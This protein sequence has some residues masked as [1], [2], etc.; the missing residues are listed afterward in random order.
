M[1]N[2][3]RLFESAFGT[4]LERVIPLEENLVPIDG[5]TAGSLLWGSPA[6]APKQYLIQSDID[7]FMTS[8]EPGYFLVGFWGH[9]INSSAFYYSRVNAWSRVLFRLPYG[10]VYTDNDTMAQHIVQF[11]T[12]YFDFERELSK[13]VKD[14]IAIE[15]MHKAYYRIEMPDSKL[16]ESKKSLLASADFEMEFGLFLAGYEF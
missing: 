3:K 5:S 14:F 15:S 12:H 4:A 6:A 8:C 2:L 11:L 1:K 16:Y 7:P 13:T 9:G 10:G